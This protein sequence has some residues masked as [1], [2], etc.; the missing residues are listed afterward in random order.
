MNA[1]RHSGT[2]AMTLLL[3]TLVAG[4]GGGGEE[5]SVPTDAAGA[6]TAAPTTPTTP[7]TPVN[8]G[9]AVDPISEANGTTDSAGGSAGS[10]PAPG[11]GD[12]LDDPLADGSGG[13]FD[14]QADFEALVE[15]TGDATAST[16]ATGATS[17]GDTFT[18]TTPTTSTTPTDTTTTTSTA[19]Y[20]SAK[21]EVNGKVYT[22]KKASVFPSDTE[23]FVLKKIYAKEVILELTAGEF[24]GGAYG[25]TLK[26]GRRAKFVNT[27]EGITYYLKLVST[28]SDTSSF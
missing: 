17:F 14:A 24:V 22:L 2:I 7:G 28:G 15:T 11:D 16:D 20:T 3:A 21:I 19:T 23:Q 8:S 25:I 12:E 27:N 13:L 5:T 18:P 1:K 6:T 4:C 10:L 26:Q 9:G